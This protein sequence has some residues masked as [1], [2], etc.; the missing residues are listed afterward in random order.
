[1]LK[2]IEPECKRFFT[3]EEDGKTMGLSEN[4]DINVALDILENPSLYVPTASSSERLE[5]YNPV[6]SYA[7][8]A[9][10]SS[11]PSAH[12]SV[13][14]A[15]PA[16]TDQLQQPQTYGGG[17]Q[18]PAPYPTQPGGY[19]QHPAGSGIP[20]TFPTMPPGAQMP[21]TVQQLPGSYAGGYVNAEAEAAAARA[22]VEAKA[23]AARDLEMRQQQQLPTMHCTPCGPPRP[24]VQKQDGSA[25]VALG[26]ICDH[27]SP[28]HHEAAVHDHLLAKAMYGQFV[29]DWTNHWSN[30]MDDQIFACTTTGYGSAAVP[31][32]LMSQKEI[33]ILGR[34][35][36]G[37]AHFHKRKD[38]GT[39]A[40]YQDCSD[41]KM[42]HDDYASL[43]EAQVDLM[44][45]K[46]VDNAQRP[47]Q[48][49]APTQRQQHHQQ[50][51][52]Q[53]QGGVKP[54][55]KWPAAG[56][57]GGQPPHKQQQQ[58]N[59]QEQQQQESVDETTGKKKKI[60]VPK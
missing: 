2:W 37:A 40:V 49:R 16:M 42:N 50:Q 38:I 36:K 14:L 3:L 58:H 8:P 28:G 19:P 22:L 47:R 10:D 1:M 5:R 13:I 30:K 23:A 18:T 12:A 39:G 32:K 20:P 56:G 52:Q 17:V 53:Q 60:R 55:Q 57:Q 59:Q 44:V 54:Q 45:S 51:Q 4:I 25:C 31:K 26:E 33:E 7:P 24:P 35:W 34:C 21:P 15:C 48:P 6:N 46:L 27:A 11:F 41:C 29:L 9:G 43:T